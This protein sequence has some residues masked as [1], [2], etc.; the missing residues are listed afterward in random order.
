MSN[1]TSD[2]PVAEIE[3]QAL[4]HRNERVRRLKKAWVS[5]ILIRP[6]S[7]LLPLITVPLFLKYLGQERYGMYETM[8]ALASWLAATNLG[9]TLALMNYLVD[10]SVRE[11]RESARNAVSTLVVF[12]GGMLVVM[13][14]LVTIVT[15]LVNWSRFFNLETAAA[16]HEASITFWIAATATL[17]GLV[18]S[19]PGSIYGGYQEFHRS[20]IW[21]GVSRVATLAACVLVV[22][23]SWGTAGV[24]LAIAGV[25]S[26]VRLV[27]LFTLLSYE[28]PFLWPSLER[29]DWNL[30][31]ELFSKGILILLLQ[32]SCGM[33]FQLDKL[34]IGTLLGT[35]EVTAY[36]ILGRVYI[37][38]YGVFMLLL[39]PLWVSYGE[40]IKRG[41]IAWV[42]QMVQRTSVAGCAIMGSLGIALLLFG[43][44]IMALLPGD[45]ERLHVS[46]SL[47]VALTL[48]F[49]TRAWV[50]CRS[51]VL[52]SANVLAPQILFYTGHALLNL[53]IAI[54]A[55]RRW[56]VEGIAWSTP[57]SAILTAVWGYPWLMGRYIYQRKISAK[58][59]L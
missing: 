45:H 9:L 1:V 2:D 52:L 25:P 33:L 11:D 53:A 30:L 46:N 24:I 26:L 47:I 32:L 15:P 43:T 39:Q 48:T 31:K 36:S 29:F 56:G 37:A 8:G 14:A 18:A 38:G 41:D 22:F 21:D 58:G 50:D 34:L 5:S 59:P 55:G 51:V 10:C 17:L 12:L 40:T 44:R 54:P 6:L 13:V 20:N 7:F 4:L 57:I 16:Q 49:V 19:L 35:S 42:R 23:T 28:K 27:N 3:A